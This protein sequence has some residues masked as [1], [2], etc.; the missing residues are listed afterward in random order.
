MSHFLFCS[1][2]TEASARYYNHDAYKTNHS[3]ENQS[4]IH[5]TTQKHPTPTTIYYHISLSVYRGRLKFITAFKYPAVEKQIV[6]VLL[7]IC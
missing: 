3:L 6:D 7:I 2:D 5:H 1:L 4:V